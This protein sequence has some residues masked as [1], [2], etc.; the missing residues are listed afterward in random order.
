LNDTCFSWPHLHDWKGQWPG[1][2][3]R[4]FG[5]GYDST[6]GEF[7]YIRNTTG[8]T[9]LHVAP[10]QGSD[11]ARQSQSNTTGYD[12]G[13]EDADQTSRNIIAF[14]TSGELSLSSFGGAYVYLDV[15]PGTALS[16]AYW[17]AWAT[18]V[19]HYALSDGSEPYFPAVY[20]QFVQSSGVWLPQGSVQTALNK[21]CSDYPAAAV[22]CYA[23]WTGNPETAAMCAPDGIPDWSAL[24]KFTQNLCGGSTFTVPNLL[25][26]YAEPCSCVGYGYSKYAGIS[27]CADFFD[28]SGQGYPNNNLDMDGSDDTGAETYM[29]TIN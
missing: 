7:T 8:G 17:A 25:Y 27:N 4:Y 2:V 26:Q 5:G 6:A 23:F 13:A 12:N 24:G 20:T 22:Q 29:L 19:Y 10:L 9:C 14:L 16:P 18:T 3:G 28:C 11:S 15:E 1:F 21:A